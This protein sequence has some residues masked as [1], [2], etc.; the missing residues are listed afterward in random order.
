MDRDI[1][2]IIQGLPAKY[3]I[4]GYK[5]FMSDAGKKLPAVLQTV[6]ES[7]P[8]L[9]TF[10]FLERPSGLTIAGLRNDFTDEAEA[11]SEAWH[12]LEGVLDAVCLLAEGIRIKV[13]S[14]CMIREANGGEVALKGY[15]AE[16]W[17]KWGS[18]DVGPNDD[19]RN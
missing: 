15:L 12:R 19:W 9:R 13:G 2:F 1:L 18:A 4:S 14:V 11:V 6:A 10:L 3:R 17:A 7:I 8:D 5:L 16:G